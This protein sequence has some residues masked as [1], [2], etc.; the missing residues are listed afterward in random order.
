MVLSELILELQYEVDW[1]VHLP[2]LL[3]VALL[4]LDPMRPLVYE[5]SIAMLGNLVIVLA[6]KDNMSAALQ[7]R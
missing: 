6:C 3:H 4:G 5:H 7:A 2:L 1:Y